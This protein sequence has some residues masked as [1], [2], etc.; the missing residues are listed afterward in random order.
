VRLVD[1]AYGSKPE[2]SS[3]T[4]YDDLAAAGVQVVVNDLLPL[5]KTGLSPDRVHDASY[6][7]SRPCRRP[8]R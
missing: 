2:G 3:K 1:D 6:A 7:M 4:V 5:C 8:G